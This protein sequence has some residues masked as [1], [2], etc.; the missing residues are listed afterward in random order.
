M[1]DAKVG[2]PVKSG[3]REEKGF[4]FQLFISRPEPQSVPGFPSSSR[5]QSFGN[6]RERRGD[7]SRVCLWPWL[8]ESRAS[9]ALPQQRFPRQSKV[10]GSKS[11]DSSLS[12]LEQGT[13]PSLQRSPSRSQL[14]CDCWIS[15][16]LGLVPVPPGPERS[17]PWPGER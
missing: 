5:R 16:F 7:E 12:S 1:S 11:Q 15:F 8:R 3:E 2:Y 10:Q 13:P 4:N 9:S 6:S 17:S 14:P